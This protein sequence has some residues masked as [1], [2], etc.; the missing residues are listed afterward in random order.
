MSVFEDILKSVSAYPEDEQVVRL[1]DKISEEEKKPEPDETYPKGPNIVLT[2][3]I[4]ESFQSH[5]TYMT[6]ES[7]FP[8][9]YLICIW[10][11]KDAES[12]FIKKST[13]ILPGELTAKKIMEKFAIAY[14]HRNREINI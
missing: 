13:M 14:L 6:L 5:K 3:P 7:D 4:K 1:C 8:R 9:Q 2:L 12:K 10:E 11:K